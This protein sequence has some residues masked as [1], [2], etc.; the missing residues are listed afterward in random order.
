MQ[1]PVAEP[2]RLP[3][4]RLAAQALA[5]AQTQPYHALRQNCICFADFMARVRLA[6]R[7]SCSC[8]LCLDTCSFCLHS[9]CF[10]CFMAQVSQLLCCKR[11]L[12]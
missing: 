9:I 2:A 12:G 10:A 5:F 1:P 4:P 3:H 11:Q 8:L 6:D 7:V